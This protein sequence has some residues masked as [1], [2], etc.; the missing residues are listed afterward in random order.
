MFNAFFLTEIHPIQQSR[1]VVVIGV[2]CTKLH[3]GLCLFLYQQ[4]S[5]V[6]YIFFPT[7]QC[8]IMVINVITQNSLDTLISSALKLIRKRFCP[9]ELA[10]SYFQL[11]HYQKR[12]LKKK[13][14]FKIC[15]I[16][17][18]NCYITIS[19]TSSFSFKQNLS[20]HGNI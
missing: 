8:S 14:F 4:Y 17:A 2:T 18:L 19:L 15:S 7:T 11:F 13:V 16:P 20:F 6:V 3:T 5:I 9:K 1:I 12:I 10:V